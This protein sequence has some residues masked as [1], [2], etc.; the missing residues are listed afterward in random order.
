MVLDIRC[1]DA[2]FHLSSYVH[3]LHTSLGAYSLAVN[4][5]HKKTPPPVIPGGGLVTSFATDAQRATVA[6]QERRFWIVEKVSR[7]I[8]I[9]TLIYDSSASKVPEIG[10]VADNAVGGARVGRARGQLNLTISG[11]K[12]YNYLLRFPKITLIKAMTRKSTR[13]GTATENRGS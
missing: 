8:T 10:K 6:T 1:S 4:V 3:T 5:R 13:A 9:N 2:G 12:S 7:L 11:P